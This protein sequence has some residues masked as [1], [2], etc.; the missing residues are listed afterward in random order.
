MKLD[1]LAGVGAYTIFIGR[2]LRRLPRLGKRSQ[3]FLLQL[4][5][6]G[7]DS[8][9]LIILTSSF[10]GLV[11]A[12]QLVYQGRGYIPEHLFS[13]L[14]S[15]STLIELA[16]LLTAMVLTGKIGAAIAAEI[17]TMKVSEQL[18]AL[19]SMSIEAEEFLYLPR[20]VAGVISLPLL[21]VV[22]SVVGIGSAWFFN[23]IRNGLHYHTYFHNI[24]SYFQTFDLLSGLV[25][26]TVFGFVITSLACYFGDRTSGGAEGVG[27]ST[28]L[29]VVY[30]AVWVMVLDFIVAFIILG[31][32]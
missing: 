7:V 9:L 3:E 17:G 10:T 20:I 27:R 12:L 30:S 15:K 23:W 13:V 4:K 31:Q 6:I 32:V 22:A 24:R 19:K 18:D 21:S 29:T 2:V 16:P 14:I 8:L 11:T 26:A 1:F 5:R 28:M 25:K